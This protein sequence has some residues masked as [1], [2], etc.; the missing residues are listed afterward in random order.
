MKILLKKK[1]ANTFKVEQLGRLQ[2]IME[3][4]LHAQN[5]VH[6]INTWLPSRLRYGAEIISLEVF[7]LSRSDKKTRNA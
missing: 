2:L 5:K 7:D 3:S 4:R 6:V 1:M